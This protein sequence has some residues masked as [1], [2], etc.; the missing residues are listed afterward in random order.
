MR[1]TCPFC[2]PRDLREFTYRG[3]ATLRRP[4][5][6]AANAASAFADYVY[7][8][9]NPRGPHRE[10]WYH[11]AGCRAWLVVERDTATHAIGRVALARND[12]P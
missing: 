2:G 9:A 5:P 3:D 10:H 11:A 4:D 7:L 1:L 6:D 12:Q 8:R